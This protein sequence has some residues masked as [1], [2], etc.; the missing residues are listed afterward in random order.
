MVYKIAVDDK[1][2]FRFAELHPVRLMVDRAVTFL[3]ENNVAD[4]IR[5]SICTES[6]VRQT[7]STQQISTF[8][9]VLAGRRILAVQR[10]AA[11]DEGHNAARTHLVDG[12]G[13]EIVVDAET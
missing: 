1:T 11:G 6:I 2:I 5:T 13:E 3:E 10:V 9:N 7:D 12:F 4:Y 8:R